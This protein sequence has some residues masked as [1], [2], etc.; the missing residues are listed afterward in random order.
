MFKKDQE[1]VACYLRQ[2]KMN[3]ILKGKNFNKDKRT[4]YAYIRFPFFFVT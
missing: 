4:G 3:D 1:Q 2:G